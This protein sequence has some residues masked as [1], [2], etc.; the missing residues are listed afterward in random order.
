[1]KTNLGFV[2]LLFLPLCLHAQVSD[3][4]LDAVFPTPMF[5]TID[6]PGAVAT[7]VNA[8]NNSGRV[9]GGFD[10]SD[11]RT[12]AF[13]YSNGRFQEMVR[14]GFYA[15]SYG[16]N[17]SDEVVGTFTPN[18]QYGFLFMAGAYR[19]L[20]FGFQGTYAAGINNNGDVVGAY[21]DVCCDLHGYLLQRPFALTTFD[22][23]G[24]DR[25]EA[26]GINEAGQIVGIWR[27]VNQVRHGYLLQDGVFTSVD[28]PGATLTLALGINSAG[29]IAGTFVDAAGASHGFLSH[30]GSFFTLDFPD[31]VSTELSGIN[32]LGIFA[33]AYTDTAGVQ[34][35]FFGH[36]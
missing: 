2:A 27:D 12:H 16:V 9:V 29:V 28:V 20:S 1:M 13:S 30:N 25:T 34:H 26:E 23:P 33:G 14:P 15:E 5:V 17:D 7:R 11:G 31:A 4:A 8:I 19:T 6:V 22:Y 18:F 10:S 3:P 36:R 35:G 24:A 32:R 21:W